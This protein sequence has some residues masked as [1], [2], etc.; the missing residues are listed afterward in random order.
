MYESP[1]K[2]RTPTKNSQVEEDD[3]TLIKQNNFEVDLYDLSQEEVS[4]HDMNSEDEYDCLVARSV[5]VLRVKWSEPNSDAHLENWVNSL[6]DRTIISTQGESIC[7][8]EEYQVW[9]KELSYLDPY[10]RNS[11]GHDTN[12]ASKQ[13]KC[14]RI[15]LTKEATNLIFPSPAI[16]PYEG[17]PI[18]VK[19]Y[20]VEVVAFQLGQAV[21][22]IHINW[23]DQVSLSLNGLC[24]CV[25]LSKHVCREPSV[26]VG[27][28]LGTN[29]PKDPV[30]KY[31]RAFSKSVGKKLAGSIFGSKPVS[32]NFIGN[33]LLCPKK[34][35]VNRP[36]EI[37]PNHLKRCYH[38]TVVV[39][40]K[41]PSKRQLL[42]YIFQLMRAYGQNFNQ[43]PLSNAPT[44]DTILNPRFNRFF[45]LSR[46][47][48]VSISWPI[49]TDTDLFEIKKWWKI[50]HG[51]YLIL[52]NHVL[53]EKSVL[54][55]LS[56]LSANSGQ[57]LRMLEEPD[58]KIEEL[59]GIRTELF[60][61]AN[62]MTIYTLEMSY[63]DCGGLPE[64]VDFFNTLR[65]IQNIR[66]QRSKVREEIN[67]VLGL[68]DNS[69]VEEQRR[70]D[71]RKRKKEKKEKQ[72]RVLAEKVNEQKKQKR[73]EKMLGIVSSFTVPMVIVASIFGMNLDDLP[74]EVPF[75][76]LLIITFFVSL[77]LLLLFFVLSRKKIN[78]KPWKQQLVHEEEEDEDDYL[79]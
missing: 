60:S 42:E 6:L 45:G 25:F 1:K 46:S 74:T 63:D 59:Y 55:E 32:L 57:L 20:K 22:N 7:L 19:I 29:F 48:T 56:N 65:K 35:D 18:Q 14:Q 75:W 15:N 28:Q 8:W 58:I 37:I 76:P 38:Q 34:R 26:L 72:K 51:I 17:D 16:V 64:Y 71:I 5:L 36:P 12:R 3:D 9:P 27:W 4:N 33:W 44:L 40:D 31:Q 2:R 41:E 13:T 30:D 49:G 78:L 68:V 47:G 70:L 21:L 39:I 11:L 73:F 53:G 54:M 23:L 62:L 50:F 69:F 67:D 61:L 43:P 10:F 24:N 52:N 77:I 66:L 79:L